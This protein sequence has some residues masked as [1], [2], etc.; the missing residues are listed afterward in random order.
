MTFYV[1][2]ALFAP[3]KKFKFSC[4]PLGLLL[5]SSCPPLVFLLYFPFRYKG[6]T[7]ETQ[8][9]YKRNAGAGQVQYKLNTSNAW[10]QESVEKMLNN[11]CL[12]SASR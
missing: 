10:E 9:K 12:P 3:P 2:Y 7:R 5:Y 6:N 11:P 1:F 4:I 8:E